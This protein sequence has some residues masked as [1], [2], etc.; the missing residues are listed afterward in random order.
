MP[1]GYL[2]IVLHAHLPFVRHPEHENFLEE[3]WFYEAMAETYIPLLKTLSR[4]EDDG[5]GYKLLLSLSPTLTSMMEDPLLRERFVRHLG[6]IIRLAD[7][8]TGRHGSGTERKRLAAYYADYYRDILY[9]FAEKCGGR[10]ARAFA[11]LA[12]LGNLDLMTCG[13]THA[14]FPI[15]QRNEGAVRAQLLCAREHH[16]EVFGKRPDGI[17]IPECAYYPGAEKLLAEA[18]FA[19]SFVDTHGI[20]NAASA[21]AHGVYAPLCGPE[22]VAFFGRDRETSY[23][24]W[25]AEQGYPGH[26]NYREF[27]R[28]L[29]FELPVEELAE[30]VIDG[31]IRVN[32]G[33]KYNRITSRHGG[34]KALYDPGAA[35]EQAARHAEHFL[36][37][38]MRQ[39]ER[40]AGTM[41]DR[42][43]L[44]VAPYD[45]ELYGHWW[46]E[47]PQF[48][49]YVLRKMHYD[50]DVVQC[51][52]PAEYLEQHPENQ[53]SN[54]AGSSWGGDGTYEFWV[55][56]ANQ[57]IIPGLH[58][59]ADRLTAIVDRGWK[60]KAEGYG[61][62]REEGVVRQMMRELMLAQASDWP[63]IMRTGT[64]PEYARKRVR[65]HL[66]R[67]WT[68]DAMLEPDGFDA[69]TYAAICQAD[70]IFPGCD[71]DWYASGYGKS[72]SA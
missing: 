50:Q 48:L 37:N 22:G 10:P 26:A 36:E 19:Y 53:L 34:E 52:T 18:G 31:R 38:R 21:P 6:R 51:M 59:A 11:E 45:A 13:A 65:D 3:L 28:D 33:L 29:G 42:P 8:E 17:W 69:K 39:V 27:Y 9:W 4:L 43:P 57:D 47:G 46:F 70:A 14:F 61:E 71:P 35:R 68:L 1:K 40:L 72:P 44:I 49:D 7:A 41:A 20:E 16:R 5:V 66:A 32:T 55:S 12:Q 23:Q 2:A 56:G 58:K 64:S 62:S 60:G 15:V 67:F 63:F 54:P 25:S 30:F 24:V